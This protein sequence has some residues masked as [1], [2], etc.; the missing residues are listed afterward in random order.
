MRVRHFLCWLAHGHAQILRVEPHRMWLECLSCGA[1]TR[2]W[3][4]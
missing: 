1:E 4:L 2:G 3:I